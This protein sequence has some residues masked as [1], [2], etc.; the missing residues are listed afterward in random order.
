V[1]YPFD[2]IRRDACESSRTQSRLLIEFCPGEK[3]QRN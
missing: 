2:E 1:K 3:C